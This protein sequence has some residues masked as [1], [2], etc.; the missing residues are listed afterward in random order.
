M[1]L[2]FFVFMSVVVVYCFRQIPALLTFSPNKTKDSGK[3]SFSV[4]NSPQEKGSSSSVRKSSPMVPKP[5]EFAPVRPD[6]IMP[7]IK[8]WKAP[9]PEYH[10]FSISSEDDLAFAVQT[11]VLMG[12]FDL[13]DAHLGI[14]KWSAIGN[15][16]LTRNKNEW[17]DNNTTVVSKT[18]DTDM[19][20]IQRE[21]RSSYHNLFFVVV[22]R[23]QPE[24]QA[25]QENIMLCIPQADLL[26]HGIED[27]KVVIS[28]IAQR[29]QQEL[30]YFSK[31]NFSKAQLEALQRLSLMDEMQMQMRDLPVSSSETKYGI[32]GGAAL[33]S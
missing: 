31:V 13:P 25:P 4:N 22:D 6:T 29:I 30:P 15:Q 8:L 19:V 12:L 2:Y 28:R 21:F 5:G 17:V 24:C 26:Y 33:Q 9:T 3:V 14:L 20:H 10:I 11:N 7:L 23:G 16:Y 18:L 27:E 32:N 1:T